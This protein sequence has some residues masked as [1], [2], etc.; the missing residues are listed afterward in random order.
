MSDRPCHGSE[1]ARVA[2]ICLWH[3]HRTCLLQYLVHL[4]YRALHRTLHHFCLHFLLPHRHDSLQSV[5]Q[6]LP[7]SQTPASGRCLLQKPLASRCSYCCALPTDGR[8]DSCIEPAA[9]FQPGSWQAERLALQHCLRLPAPSSALAP[10]TCQATVY[11]CMG[12]HPFKRKRSRRFICID[13]PC[14]RRSPSTYFGLYPPAQG[15][16]TALP[17]F[18]FIHK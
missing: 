16:D 2:C 4:C 8:T 11:C 9:C 13:W 3:Y 7:P 5:D 10:R 6:A 12:I 17:P 18:P 1:L 15:T 14:F